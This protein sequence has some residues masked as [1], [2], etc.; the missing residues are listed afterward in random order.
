MSGDVFE[1][2]TFFTDYIRNG[3]IFLFLQGDWTQGFNAMGVSG[4]TLIALELSHVTLSWSF[5]FLKKYVSFC[6]ICN[7]KVHQ[8]FEL[9]CFLS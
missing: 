6:I 9:G 2:K 3:L 5:K 1:I 8:N 4:S 7:L